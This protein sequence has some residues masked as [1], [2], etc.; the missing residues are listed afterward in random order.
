MSSADRPGRSLDRWTQKVFKHDM[1]VFGRTVQEIV[2]VSQDRQS[3][4][5]QLGRVILRDAS[6]TSRVLKLANSAL[7]NRSGHRFSTITRAVMMLGF[8]TVRDMALTV[9]LVDS[10]VDGVHHEQ[11]V[12]QMARSLHAATQAR[13]IAEQR[14][15]PSAEE[16][17]IS[18]LLYRIGDLAFWCF[19]GEQGEK[20]ALELQ[21]SKRP[22]DRVQL[23][24]LGFTLQQLGAKVAGEWSLSPLLEA[25]LTGRH[26]D[27]PRSK[28]VLLSHELATA[29]EKGWESEQVEEVIARLSK[30]TGVA[31]K[32]LESKLHTAAR[33]AV[34]HSA[35]YGARTVARVIPLPPNTEVETDED[36][37]EHSQRFPEPDAG[38]QLRILRELSSLD[39][40]ARHLTT[41]MEMILEGIHRG[42]G[43]DR[44]LFALL[45]ADRTTLRL[46]YLLGAESESLHDLFPIGMDSDTAAVMRHCMNIQRPIRFGR[47]APEKM[48]QLMTP[49]LGRATGSTG[50]MIAPIVVMNQPIGVF[51]A[52]RHPSGRRLDDEAF[53]GFNH[54]VQQSN[55]MLHRMR[56]RP[57]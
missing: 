53:D 17:F 20:L 11:L 22:A 38:L 6:M 49:R 15:D 50:F 56:A 30:L 13:M 41:V 1:P 42:V 27:D 19:S 32:R 5:S 29:A 16:V 36:L 28:T 55:L 9:A 26:K 12:R 18:A 54:F 25:V 57:A 44:A 45:S 48:L 2:S 31:S 21:I 3:S 33:H 35:L 10:L 7:Y 24:V 34:E 39:A 40:D 43:T 47:D 51:Y 14:N 8:D 52:D 46:K 4:A 23:D 37:D